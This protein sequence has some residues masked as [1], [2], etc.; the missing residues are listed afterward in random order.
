MLNMGEGAKLLLLI[1]KLDEKQLILLK[2]IIERR[3]K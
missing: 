1:D 2:E 3:L